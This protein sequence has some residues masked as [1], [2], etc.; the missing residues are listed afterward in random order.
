MVKYLYCDKCDGYYIL[1]SGESPDD[2][3]DKCECGGYLILGEMAEKTEEE[4]L[5]E[6]A[7][8]QLASERKREFLS[9]FST[10][11]F[12][13]A[14]SIGA[15]LGFFTIFLIPI[16]SFFTVFV[17]SSLITSFIVKK[18]VNVPSL[19]TL[20]F[21]NNNSHFKRVY[22]GIIASVCIGF[23][24]GLGI[25]AF[26]VRQ[27]GVSPSTFLAQVVLGIIFFMIIGLILGIIGGFIGVMIKDLLSK[28][29]SLYFPSEDHSEK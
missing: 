10:F 29:K 4:K 27:T 28:I 18:D 24:V 25:G 1:N 9:F 5:K 19:I 13:S 22:T 8:K 12:F 21:I 15:V 20:K 14:I 7:S 11:D 16:G 2:F 26:N 3:S 17:M 6:L 23:L